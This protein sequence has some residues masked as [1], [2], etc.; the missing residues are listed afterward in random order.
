MKNIIIQNVLFLVVLVVAPSCN[1]HKYK[2]EKKY[3]SEDLLKG[4]VHI[5]IENDL[6]TADVVEVFGNDSL[7]LKCKGYEGRGYAPLAG[8]VAFNSI[9][10]SIQLRIVLND[11]IVRNYQQKIKVKKL[12]KIVIN[13]TNITR[14]AF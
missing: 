11:T 1:F 2:I 9:K 14:S 7:L 6:D 3:K 10:S 12:N 13:K 5:W 8:T 4:N